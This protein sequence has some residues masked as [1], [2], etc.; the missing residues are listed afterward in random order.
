MKVGIKFKLV[1][2]ITALLFIIIVFL[3]FIVLRGIMEYQN[4]ERE[5]ILLKQKDLFEQYLSERFAGSSS[6]EANTKIQLVKGNV[7][8]KA[9]LRTIPASIY[10]LKGEILTGFSTDGKRNENKDRYSM[11]MKAK[12]DKT[13]YK[14]VN[15][16]IYFYSPIKYKNSTVGILEL[17]Y[18]IK[19]S[20]TFYQNIKKMFYSTGL[21][22]LL[23]G[24][25]VG[26]VYFFRFT[27][28]I[29]KIK[30]TV[31]NIQKGEFG[32]TKE[33]KRKDELGELSKGISFMS[34]TLEKNIK[35]LQN[36]RDSLSKAVEK[37]KKMDKQQKEFIGNITHEFKTPI[38]AIKA[39]SDV[40][41]MYKDDTKLMEEATISISSEC[42]RLTNMVDRILNLS[43]LE[44]YD[45]E[46]ERK[47]IRLK[48]LIEP[49]C[50]RMMGRI[51]KNNLSLSYEVE[52]LVINCDEECIRHIII[53]LIDNAIKYNQSNG[54]I[55]IKCF[56]NDK[57]I[58]IEIS[59]TGIGIPEEA[60]SKIFEPFYRVENHRSRERGGAGL[61]LALVKKLVEKQKGVIL[62]SSELNKGT[63]FIIEFQT[64]Q[65]NDV[66][67]HNCDI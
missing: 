49:I 38:T 58:N 60:I 16:V 50:A 62:V 31:R 9:W 47:D 39:Y 40:M 18:S 37:L 30:I 3:S 64:F 4:R 51:K 26:T 63:K 35:D 19:E 44:K 56:K 13:V 61:G 14:E 57:T 11:L 67:L 29:D 41:S 21:L 45:F 66:I 43:V 27:K 22:C 52:D 53:N 5:A 55:D 65:N 28:D 33:L 46:L 10:D 54:T 36:E 2:F 23:I 6:N 17:E 32:K 42:E 20:N 1:S 8:N 34:T 24:I 7:F 25:I 12:N 15:D 48:E 59:D